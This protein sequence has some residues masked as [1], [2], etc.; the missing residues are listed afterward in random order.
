M[1]KAAYTEGLGEN[2]S[3]DVRSADAV[4]DQFA[5][6]DQVSPQS[7]LQ[8]VHTLVDAF[9]AGRPTERDNAGRSLARFYE[10]T[11]DDA[12]RGEVLGELLGM[13]PRAGDLLASFVPLSKFLNPEEAAQLLTLL[14]APLAER[15]RVVADWLTN[16]STEQKPQQDGRPVR[17]DPNDIDERR[18][19]LPAR[20]KE[21]DPIGGP[22]PPAGAGEDEN[23]SLETELQKTVKDPDLSEHRRLQAARQ[24]GAAAVPPL[25]ELLR[26]GTLGQR[27]FAVAALA[28]LGKTGAAGRVVYQALRR[29]E[30]DA[31]VGGTAEAVRRGLEPT[32]P[33]TDASLRNR[34]RTAPVSDGWLG[35]ALSQSNPLNIMQ[36]AA[37]RE[38]LAIPRILGRLAQKRSAAK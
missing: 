30:S 9:W 19:H 13:G 24:L 37:G 5:R 28:D 2:V 36:A 14:S 18:H 20:I 21:S 12:T 3:T 26:G 23:S 10:S 29:L 33:N 25:I 32:N 1:G 35:R 11:T 7:V 27:E 38:L 6:G 17:D 8:A 16:S 34:L 4:I 22:D 15:L 31:T